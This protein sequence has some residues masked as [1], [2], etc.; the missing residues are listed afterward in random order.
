MELGISTRDLLAYLKR[1][2]EFIK[3]A[4][5]TLE[6]PV[7]RDL[8]KNPPPG[9]KP[10][11]QRPEQSTPEATPSAAQPFVTRTPQRTRPHNHRSSHPPFNHIDDPMRRAASNLFDIPEDEVKL[12]PRR[13]GATTG[14]AQV[15]EWLLSLIS[16][17]E[18]REWLRHGLGE[19]EVHIA[20]Q[21]MQVGMRP[22]DLAM[23]LP[24]GR[25]A[26]WRLKSGESAESVAQRVREARG[27]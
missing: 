26:L 10:L 25:T 21:W 24:N 4:S 7:V 6:A 23:I 19:H 11:W 9:A 14:H 27:A 3:T 15:D 17:D 5:S 12:R 2:G 8:R 13:K 1:K 16:P 20:K 18:K 22:K